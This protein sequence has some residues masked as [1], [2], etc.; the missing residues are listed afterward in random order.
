VNLEQQLR[1]ALARADE[2]PASPDLFARVTRTLEDD[3]RHRARVRRTVGGALAFFAGAGT[4][5]AA[6]S[7]T[8]GG[9]L[10]IPGWAFEVVV[11]AAL[12]AVAVVLGPTLRRF[13]QAY[14]ADVLGRELAPRFASLLDLAYGLLCAGYVLVT[15]SL[16]ATIASTPVDPAQLSRAALR[17]GGLALSLGVTHAVTI[18]VLPALGLLLRST[19]WRSRGRPGEDPPA[20]AAD[21]VASALVGFVGAALAAAVMAAVVVLVVVVG[22][23]P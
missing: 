8:D 15:A 7:T 17:A 16:D 5:L 23:D 10:L 13:G 1:A 2:Y 14:L 18:A 6:L 3:V 9:R 12:T 21:R 22:V 19:R 11:T 20:R 4:F